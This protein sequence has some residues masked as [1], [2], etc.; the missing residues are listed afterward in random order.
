L[1]FFPPLLIEHCRL[2]VSNFVQNS[3]NPVATTK[4]VRRAVQMD[5]HLEMGESEKRAIQMRLTARAFADEKL[6]T[7]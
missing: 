4:D 1:P 5:G 3:S 6:Y 7:K 2:L